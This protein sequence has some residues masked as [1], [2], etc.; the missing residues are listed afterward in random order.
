MQREP[1][2]FDETLE[3][4]STAYVPYYRVVSVR[5]KGVGQGL[6]TLQNL[7]LL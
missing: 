4:V 1:S 2:N 7:I 5:T 3:P 6:S